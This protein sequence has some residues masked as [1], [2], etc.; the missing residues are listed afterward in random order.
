MRRTGISL[1]VR[2]TPPLRLFDGDNVRVSPAGSAKA[3]AV[4]L[5]I[6]GDLIALALYRAHADC[7]LIK[8][9]IPGLSLGFLPTALMFR[10]LEIRKIGRIIGALLL[11]SL[12]PEVVRS[13]SA[14]RA[15]I[16]AL[17]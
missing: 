8:P 7:N 1:P 2:R 15:V 6:V 12:V 13:R 14:A 9:L 16:E 10:F 4:P 3:S 11:A 17:Q 5:H